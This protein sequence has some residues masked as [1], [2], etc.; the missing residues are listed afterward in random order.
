V[1]PNRFNPVLQAL[2]VYASKDISVRAR[3]NPSIADLSFGQPDFGPP[4]HLLDAIERDDLTLEHF[5]AGA[6]RYEDAR[7]L[8]ALRQAIADWYRQRYDLVFDPDSQIMVTHGAAE[9]ITLAV[10]ATTPPRGSVALCDPSYMLYARNVTVLDRQVKR[11]RRCAGE[12]EYAELFRSDRAPDAQAFIVNSPENPTGY[13]ASWTDWERIGM[14]AAE[15]GA[16][17][18]H[19]EAY[20]VFDGE[21]AHTPALAVDA[22]KDK[23]LLVNSVSKKFGLPGLRIGWLIGPPAIIDLAAKAHDYL[24]LGVNVQ[25][26]RVALRL[27][28]D[29]GRSTWFD[30][31][32]RCLRRRA[33]L[34]V[35]ALGGDIGYR[36]PRRPMGA[37]FLFPQVDGIHERMPARY[38]RAPT[39]GAGVAEFLL[40]QHQVA[41]VPGAVYGR[42][43][44]RHVRLVLST[45][46]AVFSLALERLA[47]LWDGSHA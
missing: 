5:L 6:K 33:A 30:H 16:W 25:S 42:E 37:M 12:H 21:R 41:V 28:A 34:A 3:A 8:P 45:S 43:G 19:D 11:L 9:A 31:T 4:P 1:N 2:D 44:E 7:G 17:V 20:D 14:A 27:L 38:R 36:W 13:I 23:A 15:A 39:V 40:E 29:G 24:Y 10:L 35:Q 46:D 26:E 47:R 22:L 32:A 18:I